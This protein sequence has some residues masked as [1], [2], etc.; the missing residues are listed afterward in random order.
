MPRI[1]DVIKDL[2]IDEATFWKVYEKVMGKKITSKVVTVSDA[3]LEKIKYVV[4]QLPKKSAK[5]EAPVVKKTDDSKILK[6]WEIGFWWGF[7]SWLWFWKQEETT[8]IETE[9]DELQLHNIEIPTLGK[10]E[11]T[12]EEISFS[13]PNAKVIARAQPR[14]EKK[15][16]YNNK[17]DFKNKQKAWGNISIEQST[18]KAKEKPQK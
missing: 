16:E 15:P 7:L 4:E 18:Y 6:S 13:A 14:Q 12:Q 5:K 8:S 9:E 11:P 17:K 3:N 10:E 2:N 1:V